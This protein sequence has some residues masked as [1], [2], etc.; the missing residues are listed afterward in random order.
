[1]KT[2]IEVGICDVLAVLDIHYIP[3]LTIERLS[4]LAQTRRELAQLALGI[5]G[6]FCWNT[7]KEDEPVSAKL[8][9]HVQERLWII[10]L[11]VRDIRV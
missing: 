5:G 9:V 7:C 8:H 3:R 1:M 6:L 4:Y 10:E 2:Q 11:G